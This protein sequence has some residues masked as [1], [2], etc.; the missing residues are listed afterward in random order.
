MYILKQNFIKHWKNELKN[1]RN[2][3]Q[4]LL[5]NVTIVNWEIV[6]NSCYKYFQLGKVTLKD[7]FRAL[8]HSFDE[9]IL[10]K[11][12]T[13][14]VVHYFYKRTSSQLFDRILNTPPLLFQILLN[15]FYANVLFLYPLKTS[16][17]QTFR[18]VFKGKESEYWFEIKDR[19][20][21]LHLKQKLIVR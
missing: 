2:F 9:T 5:S 13:L 12:L 16:E 1:K 18:D 20:K 8:S 14:K 3:S 17:N 21:M 10:S 15:A 19:R 6:K 11:Q 4:I 7:L